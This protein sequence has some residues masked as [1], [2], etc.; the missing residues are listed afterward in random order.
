MDSNNYGV[1]VCEKLLL[2]LLF[3]IQLRGIGYVVIEGLVWNQ[4]Y[5]VKPPI[6]PNTKFYQISILLQFYE[7]PSVSDILE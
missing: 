3:N 7:L 5:I 1:Q 4:D 6:F 2:L